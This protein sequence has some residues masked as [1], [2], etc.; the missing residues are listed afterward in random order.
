M[1]IHDYIVVGS[2]CS[3]ATAAQTLVEAGVQVTMLDVGIKKDDNL[4]V[5]DKDFITLRKTDPQ[6]YQYF[7]GKNAEGV[8]WGRVG[9]GAQI[10]PPRKYILDQ[11]NHFTPVQSSTFSNFESLSYGG[12]GL[13]WGLQSWEYN[14]E[15]LEATGLDKVRMKDAY[16]A[17][18]KRIG[19][20][21]S[22]NDATR[23]TTNSLTNYQPAPQM[24]RNNTSMYKKYL[25]HKK[26]FNRKGVVVGQTPLALLT[27]NLGDRKKYAYTGMDFY[28]DHG[29]S[30]WRP[31]ITVDELK[32][33]PNFSYLDGYL[34]LRFQEKKDFTEVYCLETNT[35][36]PIVFRCRKLVLGCG[37]LGS[38]RIVLRSFKKYGNKLPL[39]SNAYTYIPCVQPR[40]VGKA[41]EPRKLG[42]AQLSIY[43][44]KAKLGAQASMA[45]L[46]S[47][48]S[49]MLFRVIPQVPF[50]FV[51]ARLLMRYLSSAIIILGVYHPDAPSKS[52]Y[53][54]LVPDR[55]SPTGDKLKI[56]YTLSPDEKKEFNSRE[57]KFVKAARKLGAYPI[58]R[59]N[60][61][62]GSGIHY[63]GT[64]PFSDEEKVFTLNNSGRLHRTKSVYVADSSGFAYLP[65]QGLTLSIIANAHAVAKEALNEDQ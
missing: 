38:A 29:K 9:T 59:I 31:W 7:I 41:L 21:S 58:K 63:G 12:M 65:S 5:P 45:S 6:Q 49:L 10:T 15:D 3:A 46:H 51:D 57:K 25:D 28:A 14:N 1:K 36:K 27:K 52:K 60:P 8:N 35:N 34:V 39:L 64:I 62:F 42:F 56:A 2:G 61:G 23:L 26:R 55:K 47:Y 44:N 16:V 50:N 19:V 11:V 13:G 53:I 32:K 4:T 20:C 40:L 24:D 18:V 48:Q 33:K 43:L 37:A 30:A 22:D 54:Q 17:V